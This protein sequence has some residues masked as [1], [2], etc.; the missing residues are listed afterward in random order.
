MDRYDVAVVG[1]G[2]LGSATAYHAALKGAKVIGFEQ[3]ELGNISLQGLAAHGFKFAPAI[4]RVAAEL[5]IDGKSS[6]D[7]SKFGIPRQ[8]GASKL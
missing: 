1:L 2:A 4:G 5:A 6:D 8:A 3:F 7:V